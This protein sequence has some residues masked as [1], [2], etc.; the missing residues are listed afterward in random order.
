MA[1]ETDRAQPR[2][3]VAPLSAR[4]DPFDIRH[5]SPQQRL[6]SSELLQRDPPMQRIYVGALAALSYADNPERLPQ[7]AHSLRELMEKLPERIDL[8][9]R[10]ISLDSKTAPSLRGTA[11]LNDK[12]QQLKIDWDKKGVKSNCRQDGAWQGEIDAVLRGQLKKLEAFF[13]WVGVARPTRTKLV[14]GALRRLDRSR[15]PVPEKIEK[16]QVAVWNEVF[17][18]FQSAA[19]HGEGLDATEFD[20]YVAELER[21]LLDRLRPR[22]FE[23][24]EDI[25]ALVAEGESR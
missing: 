22:T 21:F 19:H 15:R 18:Y 20:Q 6:L 16:L 1:S 14:T 2:L 9:Q 7:A 10:G 25:A 8:E 23:D 5:L 12:V 17:D 13:V 3:P 4:A 24:F 11:G